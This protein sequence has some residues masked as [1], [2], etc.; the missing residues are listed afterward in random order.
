MK[1]LLMRDS[2]SH[3]VGSHLIGLVHLSYKRK[4]KNSEDSIEVW[5]LTYQL[6]NLAFDDFL[7]INMP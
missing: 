4:T 3:L 5:G 6:T 1:I 2:T 7:H